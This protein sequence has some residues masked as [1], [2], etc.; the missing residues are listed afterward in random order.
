MPKK[1]KKEENF[2]HRIRSIHAE[3]IDAKEWR[4]EITPTEPYLEAAGDMP[5]RPIQAP[6]KPWVNP[7]KKAKE[8]ARKEAMLQKALTKDLSNRN[9]KHPLFDDTDETSN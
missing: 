3:G 6:R 7:V 1:A 5:V 9:I 2:N 8:E 4:H